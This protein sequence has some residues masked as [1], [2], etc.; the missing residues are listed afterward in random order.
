MESVSDV[1]KIIQPNNW[2][3]S[4][5]FRFVAFYTIPIHITHTKSSTNI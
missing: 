1:F 2:M 4:V 5:D 3:A